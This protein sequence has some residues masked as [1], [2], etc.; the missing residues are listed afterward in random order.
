MVSDLLGESVYGRTAVVVYYKK[1][2]EAGYEFSMYPRLPKRMQIYRPVASHLEPI[3]FKEV[4]EEVENLYNNGNQ[5]LSSD[6][7]MVTTMGYRRSDIKRLQFFSMS[8]RKFV[9]AVS[10]I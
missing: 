2:L 8:E 1:L 10:L 5:I 7:W 9:R 4:V 3:S 6:L